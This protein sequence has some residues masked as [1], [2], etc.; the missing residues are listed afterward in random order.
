MEGI[1]EELEITTTEAP[2]TTTTTLGCL[3]TFELAQRADTEPL[4][5]IDVFDNYTATD[6]AHTCYFNDNGCELA[7]YD[8]STQRCQH[9][10]GVSVTES[11]CYGGRRYFGLIEQ[12]DVPA[13]AA[14]F[15]QCFDC[16]ERKEI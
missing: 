11:L 7:F 8:R 16:G 9:F 12:D 3:L 2:E 13:D 14:V 6:C 10:S 5:E 15:L 4:Q 1:G